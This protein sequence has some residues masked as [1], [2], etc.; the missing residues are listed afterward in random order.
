MKVRGQILVIAK[1]GRALRTV[2]NENLSI[3]INVSEKNNS[4]TTHVR[5]LRIL[6]TELYNTKEDLAAP[7][8]HEIS[9]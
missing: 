5:N 9:E 4:V 7:V 3:C 6:V 1:L 2:Y 8:M